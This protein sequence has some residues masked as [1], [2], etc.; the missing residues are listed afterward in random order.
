MGLP[1]ELVTQLGAHI[2]DRRLKPGDLLFA[3][4]EGTPFSRNTFRTR[5]W[6]PAVAASGVDF[7]RP[8][9]RPAPR[10]RVLA[11]RRRLRPQ[12]RDGP[13]GSCSDHHHPEVPPHPPRRRRQEPHRPRPD[14]QPCPRIATGASRLRGRTESGHLLKR[15][16]RREWTPSSTPSRTRSLG[17]R[18]GPPTRAPW[19]RGG[20]KPTRF[21]PHAFS[22]GR[23]D[24]TPRRASG[25]PDQTRSI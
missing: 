6:R 11:A 9:P 24:A 25:C 12:V 21:E 4:R 19:W 18:A 1:P 2:A 23:S 3:T 13:D 8:G 15:T 20:V 10:P 17:E 5:V 7:A 22:E 16:S 14:P